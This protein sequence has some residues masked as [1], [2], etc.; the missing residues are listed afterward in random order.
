[1]PDHVHMLF[2]L[3]PKYTLMDV[4]K[5]VKGACSEHINKNE[6]TK[7]RFAWQTG[8]SAYSVSES[9]LQRVYNYILR[10][11]QHHLKQSFD[12]EYNDFLAKHGFFPD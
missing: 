1:M 10:Q 3:S 8:Y 5:Q 4:I 9:A 12:K 11:K 2:R 7:K 6:L